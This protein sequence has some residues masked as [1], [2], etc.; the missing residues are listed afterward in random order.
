M[1]EAR[2]K[3]KELKGVRKSGLCPKAQVVREK[4]AVE[5]KRAEEEREIARRQYT[6]ANLVESYLAEVID[7][8]W[9][10]DSRNPEKKKRI[11]GARKPKGQSEVRRT[12]YGDAVRVLGDIPAEEITRKR[13]VDMVMGIVGRGANVQAGNVLR[14]LS[15]AYEY[16]IGLGRFDE[17][18]ANP[19]LLAKASLAQAR[20]KLTSKRGKRVLSDNELKEVL[21]WLPGSGFSAT[22]KKVLR[23]TLW[24][25]C[26]TGEVCEAQWRDIDLS[27]GVWHIRDS[28]NEA[29]R[30]IQLP[31]QAVEF[32]S[33]LKLT[34]ETYLFASSRTLLPISTKITF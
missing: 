3:L 30:Y 34:T 10:I 31:R 1:S 2:I 6:V 32:L 4:V 21:R 19:A 23:F 8:R 16:S 17:D 22:Q 20:V 24:T 26:R 18:F 25:G 13:I 5:Q 14:E 27:T 11:P 28:K 7:D 15:A 33:E 12:L 29:E 9:I